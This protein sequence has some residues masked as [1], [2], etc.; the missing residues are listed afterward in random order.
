MKDEVGKL[1]VEVIG[2]GDL[3]E[4]ERDMYCCLFD[5]EWHQFLRVTHNGEVILFEGDRMEPEDVLFMR[6]LHWVPGIIR[7]AYELGL[8]DGVSR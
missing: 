8:K 1:K 7:K 6:D 4:E 5:D 2:L 3:T